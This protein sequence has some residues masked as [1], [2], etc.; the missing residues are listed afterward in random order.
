MREL[1]MFEDILDGLSE[2]EKEIEDIHG[3]VPE[4]ELSSNN[5]WD[6]RE[7]DWDAGGSWNTDQRSPD[8]DSIWRT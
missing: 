7:D 1:K 3:P 8:E 5:G 6:A 2:I 4:P